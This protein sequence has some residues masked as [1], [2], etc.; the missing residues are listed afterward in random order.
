ML[1]LVRTKRQANFK[2]FMRFAAFKGFV[3]Q[4]IV[5]YFNEFLCKLDF[6]G[7]SGPVLNASETS[8]L[9]EYN[10]FLFDEPLEGFKSLNIFKISLTFRFDN[11]RHLS[12]SVHI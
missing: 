4:K 8:L 9:V 12:K 10:I 2:D 5:V 1:Q 6:F 3:E 7:M 11:L